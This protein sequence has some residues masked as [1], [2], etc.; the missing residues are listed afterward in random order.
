MAAVSK[1]KAYLKLRQHAVRSAMKKHKV[2]TLLL[3]TPPDL[4]YLTDF[5]GDDSIG[6]LTQKDFLLVTDF[7]Y[8]EQ[9][10][11]EAGWLKAIMR[12]AKMSD[13]LADA[14]ARTKSRR[15]GFQANRASFGQMDALEKAIKSRTKSAIDL[16]PLDDFL[17]NIRQVKDGHEI[18]I[19][20]QAV[21]VAEESYEALRKQIKIGQSE[22]FLAGMLVFEMRQRGA[23]DGSFPAIIAA[24]SNSSL[25]HYR[26]GKAVVRTNQPLLIDWGALYMGYCSDL[27]RTLLIGN[28]KSVMKDI[29]KIVLEAQLAAIQT[30]KPGVSTRQA[31]AAARNVIDRA[32]YKD[33]FGHGLG[34]GIGREI[35]ELPVLRKTGDEELLQPGMIVTV[36]PGIYLPGIGGVRIEDDVLIT[37]GGCEVLSSLNKTFEDSRLE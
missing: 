24:G 13:A 31:D 11:I 26:P 20:R 28:V 6:I 30:L 32:G 12:E 15:V 3:T 36:E 35:H 22:N 19:I 9:V 4:A 37:P 5:T 1:S 29:Y 21:K 8:R 25:P 27:T 17:V 34:H 18:S 33:R 7:R 23:S 2:D 16:V 10:E 14:L